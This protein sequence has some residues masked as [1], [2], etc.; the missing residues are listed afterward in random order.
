MIRSRLGSEKHWRAVLDRALMRFKKRT[1]QKPLRTEF[2]HMSLLN[3]NET[4]N[5]S[6]PTPAGVTSDERS[7]I[8][9]EVHFETTDGVV[10][11]CIVS[12]STRA[13]RLYT[14]LQSTSR[15]LWFTASSVSAQ[16][17]KFKHE[18]LL[19]RRFQF[20][21]LCAVKQRLF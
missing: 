12:R 16:P 20:L 19:C 5:D 14:R 8:G 13:L 11:L 2:A 15:I 18:V 7:S 4:P 10:K 1:L 17:W 21:M 3:A 9:D 6:E